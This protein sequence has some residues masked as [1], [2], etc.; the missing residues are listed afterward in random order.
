MGR[1]LSG[2]YST[3][4][5]QQE[6]GEGQSIFLKVCS[7]DITL[8]PADAPLKTWK[9]SEHPQMT[10]NGSNAE[11]RIGT[12]RD[13]VQVVNEWGRKLCSHPKKNRGPDFS[14][15]LCCFLSIL[16]E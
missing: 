14:L 10:E 13:F 6:Q 9:I 11:I 16:I 7:Y 12:K 1:L 2:V 5:I 15:T 3:F 4:N 8:D